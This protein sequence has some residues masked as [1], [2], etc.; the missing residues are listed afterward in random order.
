MLSLEGLQTRGERIIS[1]QSLY[2]SSRTFRR[3][4]DPLQSIPFHDSSRHTFL[5]RFTPDAPEGA[6]LLHSTVNISCS[7]VWVVQCHLRSHVSANIQR[8]KQCFIAQ[9]TYTCT[10]RS[11]C[12]P[13]GPPKQQERPLTS[14]CPRVR[15]RCISRE[16]ANNDTPRGLYHQ[17][18]N[19]DTEFYCYRKNLDPSP[20][21]RRHSARRYEAGNSSQACVLTH[22]G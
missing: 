11:P 8:A 10:Q 7:V 1:S 9:V 5:R 13:K 3:R 22:R 6:C 2:S 17:P 16:S 20:M 14:S 12:P 21:P 4:F 18:L 19:Q 15:T